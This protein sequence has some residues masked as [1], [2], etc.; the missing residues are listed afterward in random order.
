MEKILNTYLLR[1]NKI[2]LDITVIVSGVH[3]YLQYILTKNGYISY[4]DITDPDYEFMRSGPDIKRGS[5]HYSWFPK[6]IQE[7]IVTELNRR[8]ALRSKEYRVIKQ[9][10]V[11]KQGHSKF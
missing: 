2:S 4:M 7:G 11:I 1:T 8:A 5:E 9:G 10:Q 6:E 3:L